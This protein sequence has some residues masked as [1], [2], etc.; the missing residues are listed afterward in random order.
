MRPGLGDGS[1]PAPSD[2]ASVP[3][4]LAKAGYLPLTTLLWCE[5][6]EKWQPLSEITDLASAAASVPK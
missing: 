2:T 5:G 4:G 6:R 1:G 3:A